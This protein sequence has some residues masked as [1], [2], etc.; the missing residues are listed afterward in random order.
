MLVAQLRLVRVA[1]QAIDVGQGQRRQLGAGQ[2]FGA[3]GQAAGQGVSDLRV[4]GLRVPAFAQAQAAGRQPGRVGR[5]G[6]GLGLDLQAD[7]TGADVDQLAGPGRLR[8]GFLARV[9][10]GQGGAEGQRG[11]LQRPAALGIERVAHLDHPVAHAIDEL[12]VGARLAQL[13]HPGVAQQQRAQA[14]VVEQRHRVVDV[15]GQQ[16]L[17][18][19]IDAGLVELGFDEHRFQ[20]GVLVLG[21]AGV[22][23]QAQ[24][25]ALQA[26][27]LQRGDFQGAGVARQQGDDPAG[28]GVVVPQAVELVDLAC[29]A[30][31]ELCLQGRQVRLAELGDIG[32]LQGQL[33]GFPGI[34]LAA[35]QAGEQAGSLG[36]ASA[37]REGKQ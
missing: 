20:A 28:T 7:V 22:D 21:R 1:A 25:L 18:L 10:V 2:A 33:D 5:V 15:Q 29:A 8:A 17:G 35:V 14:A 3:Q 19:D 31:L 26:A 11:N 6:G 36:L 27:Q 34:D 37:E 13:F 23:L 30:H 16:G 4:L 12:F 9:R 32:G 24:G